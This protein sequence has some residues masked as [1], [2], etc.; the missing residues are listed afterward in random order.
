VLEVFEQHL[1]RRDDDP[2][3]PER[4]VVEQGA[5]FGFGRLLDELR[6]VMRTAFVEREIWIERE[7]DADVTELRLGARRPRADRNDRSFAMR[8]RGGATQ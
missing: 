6:D 3:V 5:G 2:R 1:G 7:A 4:A 8:Q